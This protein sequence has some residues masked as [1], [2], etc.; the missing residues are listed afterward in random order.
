MHV[1]FSVYHGIFPSY[2]KGFGYDA[3]GSKGSGHYAAEGVGCIR[4]EHHPSLPVIYRI[5]DRIRLRK[6]IDS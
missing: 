5:F 3:L 2:R 1:S 6:L 4:Y